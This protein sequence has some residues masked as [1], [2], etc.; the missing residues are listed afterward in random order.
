MNETNPALTDTQLECF[1]SFAALRAAHHR[2]LKSRSGGG[3]T[4][5]YLAAVERFVI[6]A[7]STGSLIC[8]ER[9]RCV[10]QGLVD[11]WSTVLD[12]AGRVQ[13]IVL[14]EAFKPE[15]A[16]EL[17]ESSRPYRGLSA[18]R[19]ED[20][21]VFFGREQLVGEM[22][23]KLKTTRL[24]AVLGPSG[25]G[26]SSIV[27]AGLLPVL[28]DSQEWKVYTPMVPGSN[29]LLNLAK[30]TKPKAVS[31]PEWSKNQLEA[32][33]SDPD[34]LL[35]LV[36]RPGEK[37]AVF[38]VDQFEEVFTLCSENSPER[39][40][41]ISNLL[42]L[43]LASGKRHSVIL[44]MREDYEP[45]VAKLQELKPYIDQAQVRIRPLSSKELREAIEKP[46]EWAGLKFEEG[47]VEALVKEILGEPTALPLLQFTLL[48][49]W[50][51]RERNRVTWEKYNRLGG[52]R[53]ALETTADAFYEG[54][55]REEQITTKRIFLRLVRKA[56]SL[57]VTSNRVRVQSLLEMEDPKRVERV[58]QKLVDAQ[59]LRATK[60]ETPEDDQVEVAHEALI[61]NWRSL[62]DWLDEDRIAKLQRRRL[63]EVAELWRSHDKDPEGLMRG[64]L[65]REAE[66]YGDLNPL[67]TEFL[68]ASR[69][70]EEEAEKEKDR[71][72][73]KVA[74]LLV[75][76]K[77]ERDR[78]FIRELAAAAIV[79]IGT[80]SELGILLALHAVTLA[81]S[82]DGN[83]PPEAED[84]LHRA[85]QGSRL[86][87]TCIG[88]EKEVVAVAFSPDGKLLATAS[89]DATAKVWDATSAKELRTLAG[90]TGRVC[91][92]T[93]SP[94]G[95]LLATAS[96][97]AT[98]KVWDAS[99]G[100]ELQTLVGH[101]SK[102]NCVAFSPDGKLLATASGD[103]T[104]KIWDTNS[105]RN[106]LTL[107]TSIHRRGVE[108]L[109]RGLNL[110]GEP[111]LPDPGHKDE[112]CAVT[113]SPDG[114]VLATAS[115]DKTAKTWNAFTGFELLTFRGHSAKIWDIGFSPDGARLATASS[116]R[117]VK[118]WDSGSG[119]ELRTMSGPGSFLGLDFG[120]RGNR[121]A[122]ASADRTTRVWN[123]K[124]G[125]ELFT[126]LD[127]APVMDVIFSRDGKRLATANLGGTAK[128]WEATSSGGELLT[129]D[130]HT[131]YVSDIAFSADG[132]RMA[133]AGLD[134][135]VRI[136]DADSGAELAA[137]SGSDGFLGVAF[138][139]DGQY[140]AT[141]SDHAKLWDPASGLELATLSGQHGAVSDIEFSPDGRLLATTDWG[142]HTI[143]VWDV[144]SRSLLLTIPGHTDDVIRLAFSPD[145]SRLVTASLDQTAILW[146][147]ASG[148]KLFCFSSHE[149]SVS[150]RVDSV[151]GRAHSV[152]GVAFSPDGKLMATSGADKKIRLWDLPSKKE[153][154]TFAGHTNGIPQVT[155]SAD[156]KRLATVSWDGASKLW[157]PRSGSELLT[158]S[159]YGSPFVCVALSPDG[160]RLV[161]GSQD[162][163]V[164]VYWVEIE[165]LM[166][167]ARTR[168]TRELTPQERKKFL[169]EEIS[170]GSS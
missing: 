75:K 28:M 144:V 7:A 64:S 41:F 71:E 79:N 33:L 16:P 69:A 91:C 102:V 22:V 168:V 113:F 123:S 65:L 78:A 112:V 166:A 167:L 60:G 139:P 73:E 89:Y 103:K 21:S 55:L 126:L 99:T 94:D 31:A 96:D 115:F 136:W 53:V 110:V 148:E 68:R 48:K 125:Q 131:D 101:S 25:S 32:F 8:D 57:E 119:K 127:T 76:L 149:D 54:L 145:G 85:V 24:L 82:L 106:R 45:H 3:D 61:R 63:T 46:A 35:K 10:S 34:H 12:R 141:A 43:T 137:I 142:D 23:A 97:D 120:P 81:D 56:N 95:K 62:V 153:R 58:L 88:H 160:K 129:F 163:I 17:D 116:D 90:H 11:Y 122:A 42:H 98:A 150:G 66:S 162:G 165:D 156:G 157:D 4:D 132:K 19:E 47:I 104:A 155:F 49:L 93:F 30:L 27:L 51:K 67:E 124:S 29:P 143:K 26:K 18:F 87:L 117:T 121:V 114:K 147:V 164:R 169:H 77:A 74:L 1:P 128:I 140:L 100:K 38:I 154:L 152:Y 15:L 138:S 109:N 86:R 70:A 52:P 80:D 14:L 44:T 40:A 84:A 151:S 105:G 170:V 130:A 59:L 158:F 133:T 6:C 50:E 159:S 135:W 161:T 92:V 146:D 37:P 107:P 83:V 13:P 9:E 20:R 108:V 5:A 111:E 2:L 134:K 36:D 118:K 39:V 72:L